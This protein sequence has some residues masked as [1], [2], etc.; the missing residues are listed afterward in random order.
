[1]LARIHPFIFKVGNDLDNL[2][3]DILRIGSIIMIG[4]IA[5]NIFMVSTA[6]CCAIILNMYGPNTIKSIPE[7]SNWIL[8]LAGTRMS[9]TGIRLLV[10]FILPLNS[11]IFY[12]NKI[13]GSMLASILVI[14]YAFI[15][16]S[17]II[18]TLNDKTI[19]HKT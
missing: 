7:K 11:Y 14:I 18:L 12:L 2:P 15:S 13:L 1:S 5:N 17:W 6:L 10:G 3:P 19:R 9:L 4:I 16:L 8:L